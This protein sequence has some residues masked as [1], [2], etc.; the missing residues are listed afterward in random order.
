MIRD[1][2]KEIAVAW[3]VQNETAKLDNNKLWDYFLP[4]VGATEQELAEADAV[5]G[6][7]LNP[8]YREFLTYANGWRCFLQ[9]IDLF[10]TDEL[11][12]A[13]AM[14]EAYSALE[15]IDPESFAKSDVVIS[16]LLPIGLSNEQ[17]DMFVMLKPGSPNAGTIIWL[18]GYEIERFPTFGDFFLAMVDYNRLRFERLRSDH[19]VEVSKNSADGSGG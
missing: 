7:P 6:Y 13:R 12:D 4:K 9:R 16:D 1:W 11:R 19:P 10:G 3:Y 8:Q 15:D 18:A 17:S 5:L 14:Q 2:K